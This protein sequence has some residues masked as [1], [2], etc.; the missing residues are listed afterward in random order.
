MCLF[1]KLQRDSVLK[2]NCDMK[3]LADRVR[4]RRNELKLSQGE[5]GKKIGVGQSSIGNIESGRNKSA[6]FLPQ[7]ANALGVNGL[8]LAE[9]KGVMLASDQNPSTN[10]SSQPA[11]DAETTRLIALANALQA[12]EISLEE[13]TQQS[14]TSALPFYNIIINSST[15]ELEYEILSKHYF[16]H[17]AELAELGINPQDAFWCL[18]A[19]DRMQ[20]TVP[21]GA[22]LL[23]ETLDNITDI[24]ND[25]IYLF[26]WNGEL[27]CN[28]L[29]RQMNGSLLVKSDNTANYSNTTLSSDE[30]AS[31]RLIGRVRIAHSPASKL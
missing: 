18:A 27:F 5:L 29:V 13:Y 10:N 28:R 20:P 30:V 24:I 22:R 19:G 8:W 7:L 1:C 23:V 2:Y 12:G 26:T 25:K 3:T 16:T 11:E 6:T 17:N 31:M 14:D 15:G 21:D 9:G 4:A